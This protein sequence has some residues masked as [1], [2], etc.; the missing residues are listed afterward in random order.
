MIMLLCLYGWLFIKYYVFISL[1]YGNCFADAF[2][3][4]VFWGYLYQVVPQAAHDH[5]LDVTVIRYQRTQST[6]QLQLIRT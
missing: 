5:C 4:S 2:W 1:N 6:K 3:D